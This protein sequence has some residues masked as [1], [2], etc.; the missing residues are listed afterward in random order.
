MDVKFLRTYD[1]EVLR[2]KEG[3]YN[4]S[5][6]VGDK[7]FSE[8]ENNH[9]VT[10]GKLLANVLLKKETG[11]IEVL[12]DINGSVELICDRSL[13]KFDYSLHTSQ[14]IVYKYGA[15]EKEINEEIYIITRDTPK[16]N[17]AQLIYEFILLAIP[18][19]KIHPDHWKEMDVDNDEREGMLVYS[20]EPI[21][22][23]SLSTN[24]GEATDPRWEILKK[25][26][27]KD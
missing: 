7:F 26:K 3:S 23:P 16:I 9:M 21:E 24:D 1:V 25:L 18:V 14:T 15:E 17:L 10:K 19:K 22:R 27:K 11:L 8:F 4:L 12:F 20:S 13:E 2:L 5:F 6:D